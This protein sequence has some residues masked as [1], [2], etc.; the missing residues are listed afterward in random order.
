MAG[1]T[2]FLFEVHNFII[3]RGMLLDIG[4]HIAF[5]DN[6]RVGSATFIVIVRS[7]NEQSHANDHFGLS[8]KPLKVDISK[9]NVDTV[10]SRG[11][12]Q[13]K[14]LNDSMIRVQE[15]VQEPMARVY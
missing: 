4:L 2:F 5:V 7:N 1:V 12:Q 13:V 14:D 6:A 8:E 11:D 3:E 10:A 9:L 15:V